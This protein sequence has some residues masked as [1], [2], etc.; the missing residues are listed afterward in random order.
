MPVFGNLGTI[1]VRDKDGN[2]VPV[3]VIRGE[4]GI[5]PHIGENE[6]WWIGETDTGIPANG[7]PGPEGPKGD[8]GKQGEP[9]KAFTY[10]D[11]TPE[12]LAALKGEKGD[13]GNPGVYIGS[14]DMPEDCNVQIDPDEDTFSVDDL[15]TKNEVKQLSKEK[16]DKPNGDG[17]AGQALFTNG[18]GST[19]WG[20]VSN[21]GGL[22]VTDDGNGNV[23]IVSTGGVSITDD[24]NGNVVIA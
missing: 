22:S 2:L 12:Q 8:P 15:A 6:N 7:R 5:T 19:Y 3:P 21:G 20:T 16:V 11:F 13:T 4:N 9:G 17:T 14:G 10:A 24:G 18:D 1:F 23:T